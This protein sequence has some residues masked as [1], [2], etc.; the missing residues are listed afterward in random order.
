MSLTSYFC[1]GGTMPRESVVRRRVVWDALELVSEILSEL[2]FFDDGDE[3][4]A[5]A[6]EVALDFVVC[7][8]KVVWTKVKGRRALPDDVV[9]DEGA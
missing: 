1:D 2:D 9:E 4:E 6:D 8:G 3:D 5:E 7:A